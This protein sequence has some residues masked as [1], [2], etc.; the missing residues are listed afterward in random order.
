M[1]RVQSFSGI[2]R[3]V[4]IKRVCFGGS[5]GGRVFELWGESSCRVPSSPA[6]VVHAT[7]ELF[8]VSKHWHLVGNMI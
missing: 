3:S 7:F 1:F 4:V 8:H 2:V 5:C 6:F